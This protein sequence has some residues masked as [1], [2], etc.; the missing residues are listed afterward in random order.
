MHSRL[1]MIY[2]S[3]KKRCYNPNCKSYKDYGARGITICQEWLNTERAGKGIKG[4]FLFKDWALSNG[5]AEDLTIDRIDVDKGYYPDNCRWVTR[6][7][8]NNNQ[9]RNRVITYH[10]KTQNLRQ[11]CDELN[12]KYSTIETRL[13]VYH[14]DIEKAIGGTK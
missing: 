7:V 4:W 13:N 6:K 10:G 9:R 5:Y 11:W 3:M 8:Q 14:W 12:L 1:N 2:S